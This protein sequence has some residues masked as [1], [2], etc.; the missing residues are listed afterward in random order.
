MNLQVQTYTQNHIDALVLI[1]PMKPWRI[2]GFYGKPEEHLSHET[3][4][5]LRHLQTRNSYPWV[6]IGDYN[7]IPASEEKQGRLPKAQHLMQEFRSVLIQCGLIDLGFMGNWF[8]WNN[9]REG[10]TYVQLRL[11]QAYATLE[12]REIF[13]QAQ[14]CHLIASYSDHIPILLTTQGRQPP[15]RK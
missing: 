7:E 2:T 6:C 5:L 8:T 12:W 14:V 15:I 9:G 10:D 4:S 11:D 1:D 3:W 13:S